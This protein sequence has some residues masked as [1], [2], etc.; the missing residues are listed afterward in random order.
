M[1]IQWLPEMSTSFCGKQSAGKLNFGHQKV[2]FRQENERFWETFVYR[3][4]PKTNSTRTSLEI[5]C[6]SKPFYTGF[7]WLVSAKTFVSNLRFCGVFPVLKQTMPKKVCFRTGT[8]GEDFCTESLFHWAETNLSAKSLFLLKKG[9]FPKVCFPGLKLAFWRSPSHSFAAHLSNTAPL[10]RF[11]QN[12][13]AKTTAPQKQGLRQ[14]YGSAKTTAPPK[15][16]LRQ[17]NGSAKTTAPPKLYGSAKTTVPPKLRLR[18]NN[19]S[20]KTTAPPKL[21]LVAVVVVVVVVVV[22]AFHFSRHPARFA[23]KCWFPFR[24]CG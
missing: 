16:W 3:E 22:V 6:W 23:W 24:W 1:A 13:S 21:R 2:C 11:R 18:Q 17:N 12:G 10:K 4:K 9:L 14:N 19:G 7:S 8:P 5:N 20:A 15:L